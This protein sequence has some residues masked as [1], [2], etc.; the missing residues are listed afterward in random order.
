[1]K[2]K[3][4]VRMI[5]EDDIPRLGEFYVRVWP[6]IH[7]YKYPERMNW[8]IKENPFIPETINYPIW[9]AEYESEIVGHTSALVVPYIVEEQ[10]VLCSNSIDT[11]VDHDY[12]GY[13][14]GQKLQMFNRNSNKLFVSIGSAKINQHIKVKQGN[15]YGADVFSMHYFY[16]LDKHH[17]VKSINDKF[18]KKNKIIGQAI[19]FLKLPNLF[20]KLLELV[21]RSPK[22]SSKFNLS[23]IEVQE[24]DFRFDEVWKKCKR[25]YEL[26]ADRTSRYLDWK[27]S[28]VPDFEYNKI[29]IVDEDK[30]NI[31]VLVYRVGTPNEN[32]V[33]LIAELFFVEHK[34]SWYKDT[35]SYLNNVFS[36]QNVTSINFYTAEQEV[37]NIAKKCGYKHVET[38]TPMYFTHFDTTKPFN[39]MKTLI[40]RGESD[41]DQYGSLH[42]SFLSDLI[43][44]VFKR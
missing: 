16:N 7:K 10:D 38:I 28:K 21:I 31:G 34:E 24:F 22:S 37:S 1:M 40:T 41:L 6:D 14:L 18:I 13:G 43:K 20:S 8:I 29:I 42:Q 39:E 35:F 23:F 11:I 25:R 3:F 4:I 19:K 33:A 36:K 2:E 5:N 12:R 17:I 30:N 9:I 26:T 32:R 15:K 27:Y 44:A